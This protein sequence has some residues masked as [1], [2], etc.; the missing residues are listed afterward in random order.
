MLLSQDVLYLLD[1]S[2]SM[3]TL[4]NQLPPHTQK[5]LLSSKSLSG[6]TKCFTAIHSFFIHSITLG[7]LGGVIYFILHYKPLASVGSME[8]K[9]D[10]PLARYLA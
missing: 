3:K 4:C 5:N 6:D 10:L 7:G 8:A 2:H 1:V 9:M